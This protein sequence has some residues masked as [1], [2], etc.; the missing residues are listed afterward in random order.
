MDGPKKFY[1]R[2]RRLFQRSL[3]LG[4]TLFRLLVVKPVHELGSPVLRLAVRI[5]Q[6]LFFTLKDMG[7]NRTNVRTAS[8]SF[9]TLFS[10][11]PLLAIIFA[12]AKTMGY[13]DLLLENLY[14]LFPQSPEI[15]DYCVD[16]AERTLA[17]TRGGWMAAVAGVAILWSALSLIEELVKAVNEPWKITSR[18]GMTRYGVYLC[19]LIFF[20]AFWVGAEVLG[21][22]LR[23][24]LGIGAHPLWR[25]LSR[26]VTAAIEFGCFI[27]FYKLVPRTRVQWSSA[28]TAGLTA[29]T[30]FLLFHWAYTTILWNVT[31]YNAI[32][33]SFAAL[34]LFLF[35][36]RYS[37][38]ILLTGNELAYAHQNLH[39]LREERRE[40]H[41]KNTGT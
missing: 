31:S 20:P 28:A 24:L 23:D 17:R 8:L 22:C 38:Q 19:I 39:L 6:L 3:R 4:R 14:A 33:G 35:W 7:L 37:W 25:M 12:A 5:F 9:Y 2:I 34:P 27:L 1:R 21:L 10:I 32:Y 16:F 30:V 11:V 36:V 41:A 18:R 13:I 40:Q 15:V 29:G 26:V